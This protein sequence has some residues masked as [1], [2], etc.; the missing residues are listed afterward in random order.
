[1]SA[2]SPK[3]EGAASFLQMTNKDNTANSHSDEDNEGTI[4]KF[5]KLSESL[6]N[7]SK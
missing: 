5:K 7:F 6:M 1:M 4:S 2:A 3:F